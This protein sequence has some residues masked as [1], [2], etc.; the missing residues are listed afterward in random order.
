[1]GCGASEKEAVALWRQ[2]G[3]LGAQVRTAG[4]LLTRSCPATLP[5][6]APTK[7]W[8]HTLVSGRDTV[9]LLAVNDNIASDRLGTVVVPLPKTV[10]KLALPNWLSSVQA[11]EITPEGTR[12]VDW[13]FSD[14]EIVLDL[15]STR[16]A[17]MIVVT[18]DEALRASLEQIH[19]EQFAK[20][21]RSLMQEAE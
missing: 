11:F 7:L 15:G 18:G 13:R 4:R 17:R 14:S 2:I 16:L 10:V 5:V 21:V 3:L 12:D 9:V 8:T 6:K 20:N 19:R 1:M